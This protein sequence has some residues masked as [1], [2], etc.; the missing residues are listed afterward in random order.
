MHRMEQRRNREC[1]EGRNHYYMLSQSDPFIYCVHGCERIYYVNLEDE[2]KNEIAQLDFLVEQIG[3]SSHAPGIGRFIGCLTIDAAVELLNHYNENEDLYFE[4]KEMCETHSWLI[5]KNFQHCEFCGS[6]KLDEQ[7]TLFP[8]LSQTICEKRI[9]V[10][11]VLLLK[12]LEVGQTKEKLSE[13]LFN[14]YPDALLYKMSSKLEN[15]FEC[16]RHC[17]FPINFQI[18]QHCEK[19]VKEGLVTFMVEW[20][21]FSCI[22]ETCKNSMTIYNDEISVDETESVYSV[23]DGVKLLTQFHKELDR[24]F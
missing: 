19:T 3:L 16:V 18:P 12:Y 9:V 14:L 17:N 1:R 7:D 2:K 8:E 20:N 24:D 13:N 10:A 22:V 21:T 15:W 5:K 4:E 23:D 11:N 6:W